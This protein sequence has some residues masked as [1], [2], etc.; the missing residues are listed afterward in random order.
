MKRKLISFLLAGTMLCLFGDASIRQNATITRST[1][2]TH[3]QQ[4]RLRGYGNGLLPRWLPEY[5]AGNPRMGI[6]LIQIPGGNGS[7]PHLPTAADVGT[8]SSKG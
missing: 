6:F 2:V 4:K 7:N 1:I 8:L 3:S 5:T